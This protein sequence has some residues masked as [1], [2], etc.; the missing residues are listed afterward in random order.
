MAE[1]RRTNHKTILAKGLAYR[2][3]NREK[4]TAAGREYRKTNK[5]KTRASQRKRAGTANG[6][7]TKLVY[8]CKRRATKHKLSFTITLKHLINLYE[9]QQHLCTVTKR[10]M[11]LGEAKGRHPNKASVDRIDPSKG[12]TIDNVRLV[13]YWVNVAKSEWSDAVLLD[14]CQAIKV[15]MEAAPR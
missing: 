11:I 15:S 5:A 13:C 1:Y 8:M 7:F 10:E 3:A 14:W 6:Y 4:L 2:R 12:Y 9:N